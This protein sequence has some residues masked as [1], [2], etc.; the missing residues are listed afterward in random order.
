MSGSLTGLALGAA[1]LATS[2]LADTGFMLLGPLVFTDFAL[3]ERV[4]HGGRQALTIHQLPGGARVIDAMGQ[5]PA[6]I[7]WSG[8]F[9]GVLAQAQAQQ[10]DALW[11]AGQPLDLFWGTTLLTVVIK[12]CTL[13]DRY[14]QT[15]YRLTCTVLPDIL[16][17]GGTDPGQADGSGGDGTPPATPDAAQQQ[18]NAGLT[19]AAAAAAPPTPALPV[20][21]IPPATYNDAVPAGGTFV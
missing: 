16:V 11:R 5:D 14:M 21:P 20:P 19:R 9:L 17:A 3:P 7:T 15:D 10:L 8:M 18:G 12:E 2:I 4:G 1:S 13:D 6:D